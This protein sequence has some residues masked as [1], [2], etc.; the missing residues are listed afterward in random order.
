MTMV[1]TVNVEGRYRGFLASVMLEIAPAG[2]R[3]AGHDQR[4]PGPD[5]ERAGAV[6]RPAGQ[7]VRRDDVARSIG[8]GSAQ[9]TQPGRPAQ[10]NRGCRRRVPGKIRQSPFPL[11][12]NSE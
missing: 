12:N 6:T 7:R 3:V 9:H 11:V 8:G 10:G 1:V 5:L 4:R 2:E